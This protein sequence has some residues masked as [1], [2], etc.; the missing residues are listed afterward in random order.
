MTLS[1]H[2]VSNGLAKTELEDAFLALLPHI[3]THGRIY[4]RHIQC[5]SQKAD[6]IQEMRALGWK[7]LV[8]LHERGK[9]PSCFLRAFVT[10]LARA[11]NSGRRLAGKAKARDVLN[12]ICQKRR[13]FKVE[14][15]PTSFRA[16]QEHLYAS[17]LGQE[18]QDELEERLCDNTITPVPDQVCFRIDFPAWL[19][20]LTLRERRMVR[21]MLRNERTTDLSKRFKVTPGRI[22][23]MRRELHDDWQ[24]FCGDQD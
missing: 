17:P 13:G 22:S 10:Y 11:V 21:R 20:T 5:P 16:G 4:F 6:A 15:L 14:Y 18:L 1:S 12:P 24:R 7:W 9:D 8:R 23:Q 2:S 3:E 19:K